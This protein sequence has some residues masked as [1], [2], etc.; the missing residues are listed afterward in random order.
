MKTLYTANVTT[1]A[2]RDGTSKSDDGKIDLKLGRP[3]SSDSGTNPEQLFAAGYSACFGSA[4]AHVAKSEKIDVKEV[5]VQAKVNLNQD[6]QTGFSLSVV[7]DVSLQ[8][9]DDATAQKLVEKAHTVC[10]YSK[11]TKG[12]IDVQLNAHGSSAKAAA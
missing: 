10:P 7:L 12:N 3:G 8:G 5:Q 9:V 2:G 4:I 6:E 11:A 1:I